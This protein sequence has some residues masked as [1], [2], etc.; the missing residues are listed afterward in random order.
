MKAPA[1]F[2]GG[3]S[4]AVS[5][6][7]EQPGGQASTEGGNLAMGRSWFSLE[8]LNGSTA[9]QFIFVIQDKYVFLAK[10]VMSK[11]SLWLNTLQVGILL[12]LLCCCKISVFK[13]CCQR[14]LVYHP[15]RT[16]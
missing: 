14:A 2:F 5:D 15:D 8:C 11:V 9:S 16:L 12:V 7:T 10:S 1:E 6:R 13:V 4:R 3:P